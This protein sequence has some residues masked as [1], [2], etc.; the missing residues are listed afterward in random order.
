MDLDSESANFGKKKASKTSQFSLKHKTN[1]FTL[2][3]KLLKMTE[4]H[5]DKF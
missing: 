3:N 5:D 1:N 2:K 4:Q